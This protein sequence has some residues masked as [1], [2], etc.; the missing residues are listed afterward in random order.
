MGARKRWPG[1]MRILQENRPRRFGI[2]ESRSTVPEEIGRFEILLSSPLHYFLLRCPDCGT[3][4]KRYDVVDNEIVYGYESVEI[5]EVSAARVREIRRFEANEK[6][7]FSRRLNACLRGLGAAC[8]PQEEAV[9]QAF[10][11]LRMEH[12][13]VYEVAQI[14]PQEDRSRLQEALESLVQK[15]AL[16]RL[17][18]SGIRHYRI[19]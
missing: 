18:M 9:I 2:R 14:H 10:R 5:E 4:F 11:A 12:L 13:S 6:R 16:E 7:K 1:E 15:G 17:N 3:C 19:R 8:N